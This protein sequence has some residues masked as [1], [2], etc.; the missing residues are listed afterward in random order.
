MPCETFVF[1]GKE[2]VY[3]VHHYNNT[4]DNARCVE[5][6]IA[7]EFIEQF[8]SNQLVE[9]GNVSRHYKLYNHTIIDLYEK[10]EWPVLHE[11]ILT[12]EPD[13]QY[14]A[15]VSIST[16][17]H[18]IKPIVALKRVLGLADKVLVT[19]PLGFRPKMDAA[20]N[21]DINI[22]FMKKVAEDCWVQ[23]ERNEVDGYSYNKP[24]PY[25]NVLAVVIK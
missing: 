24:Y 14:D 5:L 7:F 12:W 17:E 1:N 25:C 3:F 2:Y 10:A 20:L 16:V 22:F 18:T 19:F 8:S 4:R 11:D 9:I 13:K 21:L 15:A 6:P 23:I